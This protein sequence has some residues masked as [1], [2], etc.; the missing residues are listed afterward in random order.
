M[1]LDDIIRNFPESEFLKADGFDSAVIGLEESSGRLIYS[2]QRIVNIMMSEGD[3]EEDALEYYYYN[4]EGAY[5]GE[6]TP[7]YCFDLLLD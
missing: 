7:I 1:I 3:T 2:V 6:K 5:V 4:M